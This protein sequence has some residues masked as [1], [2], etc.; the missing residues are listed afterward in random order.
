[1]IV[2]WTPSPVKSEPPFLRFVD[3]CDI[4]Y[5]L[6]VYDLTARCS[7]VAFEQIR[8]EGWVGDAAPVHKVSFESCLA[9]RPGRYRHEFVDD[10]WQPGCW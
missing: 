4:D 9:A 8:N 10:R 1:M 5:T 2:G 3:V 6:D 7:E